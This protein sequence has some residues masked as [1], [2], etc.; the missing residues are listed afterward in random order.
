MK[1]ILSIV[2]SSN[3]GK[4]TLLNSLIPILKQKGYTVCVIKHSASLLTYID[5]DHEGKDTY[6]YSEA[7]ADEVFLTSPQFTYH[8]CN[9]ETS[10]EEMIQ[11]SSSDIILIEGFKNSPYQK[12]L[13]KDLHENIE[14]AGEILFTIEGSYDISA[15]L[16]LILHS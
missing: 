6:S 1:K 13:I 4:T 5:F 7:G 2:G 15:I 16:E 3:K 12:I 9:Q 14:I 10:L 11:S 8:T